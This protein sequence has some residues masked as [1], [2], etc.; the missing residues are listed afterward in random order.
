MSIPNLQKEW[1]IPAQLSDLSA[2]LLWEANDRSWSDP[3]FVM[4][5]WWASFN[6]SL[7]FSVWAE[8][9]MTVNQ[10]AVVEEEER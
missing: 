8:M 2:S 6:L 1:T 4:T 7:H 9:T 3:E 5:V 10:R